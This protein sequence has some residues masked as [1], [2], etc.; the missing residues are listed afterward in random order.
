MK[1]FLEPNRASDSN[2][3]PYLLRIELPSFKHGLTCPFVVPIHWQHLKDKSIYSLDLC[4]LRLEAHSPAELA[5]EVE[6]YLPYLFRASRL[7][8]YVFIARHSRHIYPVYTVGD[9]VFVATPGGPLFRHVELAKVREYLTDYL[10]QIG[11]LWQ[12]GNRDRLHVR[13]VHSQTLGLIRPKFYLKKRAQNA[14]DNEFWAPVFPAEDESGIYT[15]AASARREVHLDGGCEVLQLR[16]LVA[17]ALIADKRLKEDYELRADRLMPDYWT[18]LKSLWQEYPAQLVW[19]GGEMDIYRH[20]QT[21]LAVEYRRNEGRY[22]LF[23]G[24]DE[25]ELRARAARDFIRRGLLDNLSKL[26]YQGKAIPAQSVQVLNAEI[27][28]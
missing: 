4:G 10:H 17:Q 2:V 23:L 8:T 9:E 22:S 21:L 24:N 20:D 11:E 3:T 13:G 7:P 18:Q 12:P 28:I 26:R 25:E 5:P 16:S 6:K 15:Y 19:A 27:P 1:I 14:K